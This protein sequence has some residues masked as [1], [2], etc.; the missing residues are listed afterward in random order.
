[1]GRKNRKF[2]SINSIR[3][4]NGILTLATHAN[5]WEPA[6]SLHELPESKFPFVSR[7]EF[8]LSNLSN[9]SA[10]VSGVTGSTRGRRLPGAIV[11]G[12]REP[13]LTALGPPS[14]DCPF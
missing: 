3:V 14:V 2:R 1:M 4:T 13:L 5:G 10:H 9:L 12:C 11:D 8:I 6:V 7:I